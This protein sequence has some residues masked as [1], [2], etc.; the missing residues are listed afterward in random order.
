VARLWP[1]QQE[2]CWVAA[3]FHDP[4]PLTQIE[5][6]IIGQGLEA[7]TMRCCRAAIITIVCACGVRFMQTVLAPDAA[8]S[9]AAGAQ[10]PVL[11]V[12]RSPL[13]VPSYFIRTPLG[14]YT[15]DQTCAM[16]DEVIT[17]DV[18]ALLLFDITQQQLRGVDARLA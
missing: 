15:A 11:N 13:A 6:C 8:R 9:D 5:S 18:G 17:S 16:I 10:P 12:L 4:A 3:S 1:A 14:E 2:F 7:A